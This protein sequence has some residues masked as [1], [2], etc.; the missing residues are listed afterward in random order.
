MTTKASTVTAETITDEQ[1]RAMQSSPADY[2]QPRLSFSLAYIC[3]VALVGNH[4]RKEARMI[5][6]RHWNA[7]HALHARRC[8]ECG[9]LCDH[10]TWDGVSCPWCRNA[11]HATDGDS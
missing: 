7:R 11:R 9:A 3:E 8:N 1:I 10:S 6:A 5:C 4:Y 2:D